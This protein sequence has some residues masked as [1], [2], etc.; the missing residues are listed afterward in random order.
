MREAALGDGELLAAI[1]QAGAAGDAPRVVLAEAIGRGVTA[2][3]IGTGGGGNRD[4]HGRNGGE[5]DR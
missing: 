2:D 5:R 1:E 3:R 4:E